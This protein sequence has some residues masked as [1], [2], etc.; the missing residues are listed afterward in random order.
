MCPDN[1]L[2]TISIP[3][4]NR[5]DLLKECLDSIVTQI[6]DEVDLLI[7]DN[8]SSDRTNGLVNEY[9]EKYPFISYS[10]NEKNLGPDANFLLCLQKGKGKYIQLLSDDDILVPGAIKAILDAIEQYRDASVIRL[11][12]SSFIK[13]YSSDIYSKPAY[14]ISQ[15]IVFKDKNL[16]LEYVGYSSIFMSTTV[17][18]REVFLTINEPQRFVGSFLLQTHILFECMSKVEYG[19]IVS[20]VCV[21]A[22]TGMPVGFNLLQVLMT[23]WKRVLYGTCLR[24]KYKKSSIRKIFRN[25][26]TKNLPGIV[27]DIHMQ[28]SEYGSVFRFIFKETWSF[29]RAWIVLY[30]YALFPGDLLRLLSKI[31]RWLT[32]D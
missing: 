1:R 29:P 19:I 4:Y 22:R 26:I 27:R 6:E 25:T 23:E 28:E 21:A 30:P 18:N 2:L 17:Y 3:T 24:C 12:C 14:D 10:R 20:E 31:K 5:C 13:K 9:H 8:A 32:I 11:N 7:N 16:F 15:D